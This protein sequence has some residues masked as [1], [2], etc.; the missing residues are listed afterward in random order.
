MPPTKS[1]RSGTC[2]ST[3]LPSSRSA[4]P[5]SR[6]ALAAVSTPK[7]STSVGIAL[8]DG[9]LGDVGGRLDAEHGHAA[10]DE[11]LQQ[12][13]VVAGDLDDLAERVRA[14]TARSS[15]G[16][17]LGVLEPARRV[18]RE[19]RVVGEDLPPASR[20]PRAAPGSSSRRRA[21]AADRTAPSRSTLL[22]RQVGFASG[23]MPRSAN[24]VAQRRAAEAAGR[25]RVMRESGAS[26]MRSASICA[27]VTA[28]MSAPVAQR[29]V[30]V[31]DA[32]R[33]PA[34]RSQRGAQPSRARAFVESSFR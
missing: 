21:R 14:R 18:R 1:L 28:R 25:R 32:R 23:D 17:A 24:D 27:S 26:G 20:T 5:R 9:D 31:D 7:N 33:A 2:A 15:L 8:L 22:R 16:V 4:W 29:L 11:V 30:P 3:L 13:A 34:S 12:V 19:V 6:R 10:L